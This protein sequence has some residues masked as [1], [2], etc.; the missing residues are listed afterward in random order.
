MID[1]PTIAT[2]LDQ[3]EANKALIQRYMDDLLSGRRE[4]FPTYFNGIQYIQH[5]PWVADTIPGLLAGLQDFPS[6]RRCTGLRSRLS[7]FSITGV[8]LHAPGARLPPNLRDSSRQWPITPAAATFQLPRVAK[9][10]GINEDA[11]RQLVA[12]HTVGRQMGF[13]GEP[14]VNVLELNLIWISNPPRHRGRTRMFHAG[15]FTAG[16]RAREDSVNH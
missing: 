16:L 9:A 14:R 4:T 7:Y 5:N 6:M 10:R 2:E 15:P 1:G 3:T 8:E 12:K 11:L 13:L